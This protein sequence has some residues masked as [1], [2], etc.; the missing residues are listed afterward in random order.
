MNEM[1]YRI[2]HWA[3]R[4]FL[5]G[6]FL[7]S[8]YTKI[9]NPL[10]FAAAVE[11]YQLLSP[12]LVLWVVKILPWLEIVLGG[13]LLLGFKIRYTA[14]L[15]ASLLLFFTLIMLATYLQGIETDCGCF[16]VGERVSPFTLVRDSLFI[17]PAL[18]LV[19][20]SWL[21]CKIGRSNR[22]TWET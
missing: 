5:G 17:L 8:G 16:G 13:V 21:E 6:I 11:G 3:C 14:A 1:I 2:L 18:F 12:G 9:E 4:I 19:V 20:Q 15:A 10:Q 7:Y 22:K